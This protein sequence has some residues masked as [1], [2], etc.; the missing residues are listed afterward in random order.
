MSRFLLMLA[1][2]MIAGGAAAQNVPAL[3]KAADSFRLPSDALR[4][5]TEIQ[6]YKS[7]T[8]DKTR[9]YTV[10]V[11]PG[12]RSL[13]LMQSPSEKGQKLLMLADEFWQI[14]PQS[15]RP[16]RIT[17]LQKLLGDASA[18]DIATM[19]WSEDYDGSVVGEESIGGIPC[20]HLALTAQRKGVSYQRVELYLSK[21]DSRPVKADLFVASDKLAK[22]ATFTVEN[23]EGRPQVSAMTLTDEIQTARQTVIRYLKRTSRAI[24]NEFYNPMFLTRNDLKE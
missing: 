10:Y 1:A 22:R 23:V 13:V 4:V 24:P 21:A 17:P 20:L 18:G 14:M 12:R 9:L 16:I 19:N 15:Q 2:A 3:L 8:L 6:L 11:K 5:E 7:G